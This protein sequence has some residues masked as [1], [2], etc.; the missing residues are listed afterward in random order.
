LVGAFGVAVI[1]AAVTKYN[2]TVKAAA[3]VRPTG[4]IRLV[5]AAT[6]G[7]IKRILV[8]ENQVMRKGDAI[9]TIEDSQLQTKKSQLQGNIQQNQLQLAQIDAGLRALQTQMTAESNSMQRAIASA[10]AD[11]RR[12]QREYKDRQITTQAEVQEAEAALELAKEEMKRYQQLGNTGAIAILQIKEKEQAFK[13]AVA[14]LQRAKT[15]LN[16]TD[17][18]V[19]IAQ[20]RIAQERA[21]GES[22]LATLNKEREELIRRQVEIQNQINSEQKDL[23]QVSTELEKTVIRTSEAGTILKLELRNPGQVLRPGEA[24]AQI[25]PSNAPLIVKA[26][27]SAED[28]SNVQV[29]QAAQVTECTKGKVQMRISAYPYP[30]YGTL[31]GAVRAITADAITPQNNGN[32]PATPYYEVTIESEKLSLQKGNK[33]YSIQAGMEVT[34]DIISK[35]ETVLTF[36]LRKARLLTDL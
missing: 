18:N 5:Q 28:V 6:E 17:A 34:A 20:Q 26:R 27:V 11:L 23:K 33:F 21:R 10:E 3:T 14:R 1:V 15:G 8:K 12:N 36:I 24:I 35:E 13:A 22:T 19:A 16:P 30:D 4:E 25:S 29:C 2:V 32:A 31:K 9:A 7:T